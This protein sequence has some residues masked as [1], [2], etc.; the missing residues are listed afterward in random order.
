MGGLTL[1]TI[2]RWALVAAA[3]VWSTGIYAAG[4]GLEFGADPS[5]FDCSPVSSSP[6]HFL[7]R[8]PP[9]PHSAFEA[10]AVQASP[11]HGICWVKGVGKDISDNRFG[12]ATKSAVDEMAQTLNRLYGP[13]QAIDIILPRALWN[14]ANEWLMSIVQNERFY[15]YQW[16]DLK[17]KRPMLD[18]VAL[19]A[20]A[21]GSSTGYIALDYY[22]TFHE[23]CSQAILAS[24]ADSL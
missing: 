18:S 20:Q 7:C 4:F 17:S 11:K 21:T 1:M 5:K 16:K 22:A 13:S 2:V 8:T 15:G 23:E 6:G 9:K 19:A 24:E 14:E 10:Y 12:S 3:M